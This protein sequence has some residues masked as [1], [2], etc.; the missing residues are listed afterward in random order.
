MTTPRVLLITGEYSP[1]SGGIADYTALLRSELD[2]QGVPS[3]VLSSAD[4]S[5]DEKVQ[6]WSWKIVAAVRKI[7]TRHNINIVHIQYQAGAFAMH[8]ALNLLPWL[9]TNVPVVTTFHDLRP[10]VLFPKAGHFRFLTMR[11]T[12]RWSA[13][14][15]VTNPQDRD[16]LRS[17]NIATTLIPLG[18]SLP[19]PDWKVEPEPSVGYF[20]FPS[21]QKGFDLLVEAIGRFPSGERPVLRVVGGNPPESAS[22]GFMSM[23]EVAE[24]AAKHD[25]EITWTGFLPSQAASNALAGCSVVAFPF[26]NGATQRSS[27]LIAALQTGRPVVT[28]EPAH[29][30]GLEALEHLPQLI[31]IRR[32]AGTYLNDALATAL[33][34]PTEWQLL[35]SEYAWRSIA[36]R[37]LDLYRTLLREARR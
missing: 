2:D 13:M 19:T 36:K 7:V 28:T 35:P 21:R 23:D 18:P 5:A 3:I 22:H 12:A 11:R 17:A 4:S 1:M 10:P 34:T 8:P 27:A 33:A 6:A 26:P 20:G 14:A 30:G 15:V 24:L 16:T 25:V 37:H 9:L 31:Q 32:G 29:P